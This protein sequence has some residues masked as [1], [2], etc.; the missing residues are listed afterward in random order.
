M[1]LR[2]GISALVLLGS[3]VTFGE[4]E[5]LQ[6]PPSTRQAGFPVDDTAYKST[7]VPTLP[8]IT[9]NMRV[10]DLA[11][12][13]R[14]WMKERMG[15]EL[16]SAFRDAVLAEMRTL[17]R[18]FP[19]AYSRRGAVKYGAPGTWTNLGPVRSQHIEN[20]VKLKKSD[21]GRVRTILVDPANADIVYLLTSGGGL[22]KT[23]NFL[24]KT[25]DWTPLSDSI[26]TAGGAMAFG[27]ASTTLHLGLGDPFDGGI[28]GFVV[29]STDGGET[30]GAPRTLG[31]AT[32]V[33][34][35]KA[36]GST[37][38]VGTNAGLW[39]STDGGNS[40]VAAGP[41]ATPFGLS[42]QNNPLF[43]AWSIVRVAGAWLVSYN[44][45]GSFGAIYRSTDGLAWTPVM[46]FSA[47]NDIGRIT[48]GVAQPHDMVVYAYAASFGNAAQKDLFRSSDAGLSWTAA[49]LAGKTPTNPNEDQP[50]MNIM[51]DQASYNQLLLVDP[52][53]ENR[54]TVYIGGQLSSAKTS[55]GGATWR[56][57]SHWLGQFGLPY[58][59]ADFHTAS[60]SPQTRTLLFGTDGGLFTSSDAAATFSDGKN[61]G[62][63]SYLVYAL[64]TNE[65][66]TNDVIIGLQDNGT[67]IRTGNG[68]TYDQIFGG[69]GFGVGWA[70][71]VSIGTLYYSFIFRNPHGTTSHED[72]WQEGWNGIDA[73]EFFNPAT[74]QFISTIYQP[75]RKA[76]PDGR[77]FYHRTKRTLYRTTNSASLWTPI[78]RLP[79]SVAGEFRGITHPIGVG[80]D[81]QQ[82]I[83]VTLSAGRVAISTDGGQNFRV[84][85]LNA[86][87]IPGFSSFSTA[88]AWAN[89]G[90]IFVSTEN[91]DPAAAH[92]VRSRD[93]GVTWQRVDQGNGL[94]ALP[95]SRILVDPR[96]RNTIYVGN[97]AGVFVSR[98]SGGT[99]EP[100]G[101]GLPVAMVNDL[102][103]PE[104]GSFL[105]IATYGR[106]IWDYRF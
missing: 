60:Y 39:R 40:F 103:M 16:S 68:T 29:T 18:R 76:A 48:L 42:T 20:E 22:W 72:K 43:T 70:E 104:D 14:E 2:F 106:G 97:W 105:R 57:T 83:G 15:G 81:N 84:E 44:A 52:T 63:S 100:L 102:Y 41:T 11:T 101:A 17:E 85:D 47:T 19:N 1:K 86:P 8:Q 74:T 93:G 5:Q 38:F 36:E 94:P 34:D 10:K 4:S 64:A 37:V 54:N 55:D 31:G 56:L 82:E 49:G 78:H 98:N 95:I 32:M 73:A 77:T 79:A 89:P 21:T 67:R 33:M 6:L 96:N 99:W 7:Y 24:R 28:G 3:I 66:H 25:P 92:L 88:V 58:V 69:D 26:S 12:A 23:T 59:H 13:R 53:D 80:Y 61:Q 90:E 75:T 51:L 35:M 9:P 45:G 71:G 50:N 62:I 27:A 46:P 30:W 65:K 87:R 91:P